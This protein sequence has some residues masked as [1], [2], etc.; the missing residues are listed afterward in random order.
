MKV[1]PKD[2]VDSGIPGRPLGVDGLA[3][4][5][6]QVAVGRWVREGSIRLS[7]TDAWEQENQG[8]NLEPQHDDSEKGVA[9]FDFNAASLEDHGH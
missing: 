6:V 1:I 4:L 5:E 8:H 9:F 3:D 7:A 2:E